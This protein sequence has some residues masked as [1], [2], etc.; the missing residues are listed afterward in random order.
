M[1]LILW[2]S[3]C[4]AIRTQ[5]LLKEHLSNKKNNL[6]KENAIFILNFGKR[7]PNSKVRIEFTNPHNKKQSVKLD[8]AVVSQDDAT[9]LLS[10]TST[11]TR[12]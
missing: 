3:S 9:H 10:K 1:S 12:I 6:P 5:T 7:E 11:T 4:P 8:I 2:P